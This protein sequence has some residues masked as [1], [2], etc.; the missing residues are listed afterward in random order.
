MPTQEVVSIELATYIA[1]LSREIKRQ[2]GILVNR[3][4]VIESVFVGN[5]RSV[6]ITNLP[7]YRTGRTVLHRIRMIHT[8]LCD[9]PHNQHH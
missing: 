7:R 5:E 2:I 6:I 9:E 3:S 8:Q 4:G 1:S